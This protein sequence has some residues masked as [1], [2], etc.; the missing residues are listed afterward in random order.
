M[1]GVFLC[2]IGLLHS[3]P[4]ETQLRKQWCMLGRQALISIEIRT[5]NFY[6]KLANEL[7]PMSGVVRCARRVTT[8]HNRED[9]R[10]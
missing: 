9:G 1:R 3:P 8:G 6:A 10:S 7:I 5:D 4:I 2:F